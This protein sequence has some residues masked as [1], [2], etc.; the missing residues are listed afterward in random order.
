V[1]TGS[2]AALDAGV[3]FPKGPRLYGSVVDTDFQGNQER[4]AV[5]WEGHEVH[6]EVSWLSRDYLNLVARK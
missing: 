3:Y 6:K 1:P 5:R 2:H 4:Y